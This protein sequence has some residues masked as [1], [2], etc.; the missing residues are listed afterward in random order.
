MTAVQGVVQQLS[1]VLADLPARVLSSQSDRGVTDLI[2]SWGVN[3]QV[4]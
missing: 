2:S 4:I 3:M 1:A